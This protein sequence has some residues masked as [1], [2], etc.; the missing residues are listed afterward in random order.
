M[1]K[2]DAHKLN[3]TED[4]KQAKGNKSAEV[5]KPGRVKKPGKDNKLSKAETGKK[6]VKDKKDKKAENI[7]MKDPL[8]KA[9]KAINSISGNSLTEADILHQRAAMER[10]GKLA[11]P[12]GDVE[13]HPFKVGDVQCERLVPEFAH[14]P[15]YAVLYAHGGG[16]LCGGLDFARILGA[17]FAIATGFTT[18]SF[19]YRLAPENTYPAALEDATAVW[20]HIREKYPADHIL[21]AG[22]SAGGNLAL[23]LAEKLLTEG[24]A[25]LNSETPDRNSDDIAAAA[26]PEATATTSMPK[27]ILLFSPWTD[28]TST[29]ES[30]DTYKDLDP[31]LTREYVSG[32]A[33]AYIAGKGAPWDPEFSPLFGELK[34]LPPVYIMAGRNEILLDDS[35]RLKDKINIAGGTAV[36]DI[37][38]NGWHVY[39]QM[40]IPIA[41]RAMKR[42]SEFVSELIYTDKEPGET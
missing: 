34:G 28:M 7:R 6:P 12:T 31:I 15:Q 33:K 41:R 5:S 36:L 35:I 10:A 11:A 25:S 30:Y 26:A 18:Y 22:D 20:E 21:L 39:Q 42:L 4:S 32:A 13:V 2:E 27:G 3:K 14:N 23:C 37:E 19:A 29:A 38:E 40:P 16:Y 1:K 8:M 17:K 24:N 9:L